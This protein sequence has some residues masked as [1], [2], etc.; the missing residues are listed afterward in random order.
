MQ[1]MNSQI[2]KAYRI[3]ENAHRG[4]KDKGGKDY[5]LHPLA[6][7]QRVDSDDEKIVALLH[8]VVEDSEITLEFL[9][10]AGFPHHIMDAIAT[11]TKKKGQDYE[12]YIKGIK[13]NRLARTVKIADMRHNSDLSRLSV[14]TAIDLK[15]VEKYSKAIEYLQN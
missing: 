7:C 13:D 9:R 11:I 6:V 1:L 8:D 12:A 2:D 14:V 10:D 4:Q 15:R 5:I 3:A